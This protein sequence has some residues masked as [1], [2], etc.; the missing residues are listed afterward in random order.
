M[1][2]KPLDRLMFVQGG[3]CFFCKQP[4]P[5]T[6][7]SVEHL[8][9]SA[10]GG[11]NSDE[12]C[13]ACCKTVNRL[14]GSMSLKEKFQVVLNQKGQFKCPN[15]VGSAKVATQSKAPVIAQPKSDK[16]A[17]VVANLKQRGNSKPRTLK[18]LKSTIVSLFPSGLPDSE[19][20]TIVQQLQSTKKVTVS[21]NKVTYAL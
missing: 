14:L 15:G 8:F 9:A 13:V 2:T 11:S 6:E 17:L 5:K 3:L 16:L 18:T 1:P 4:L 21:E 10:N 19:L 12:N 20:S 7:A